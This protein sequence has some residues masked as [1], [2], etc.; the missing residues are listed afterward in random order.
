MS[1]KGNNHIGSHSYLP[2]SVAPIIANIEEVT[3][4]AFEA[5]GCSMAWYAT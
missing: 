1:T 3:V 2:F 4:E 5:L